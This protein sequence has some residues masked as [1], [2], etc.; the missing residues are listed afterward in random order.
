MLSLKNC[1]VDRGIQQRLVNCAMLCVYLQTAWLSTKIFLLFTCL[2]Q[3]EGPH[4]ISSQKGHS[5]HHKKHRGTKSYFRTHHRIEL[6]IT[7]SWCWRGTKTEKNHQQQLHSV[8]SIAKLKK[9]RF[10]KSIRKWERTKKLNEDVH[11]QEKAY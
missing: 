6:F 7:R 8:K 5:P 3:T 9:Y 1:E 2:S 11:R 4:H 10:V